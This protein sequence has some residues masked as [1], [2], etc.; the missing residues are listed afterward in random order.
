MGYKENDR[1]LLEMIAWIENDSGLGKG[2]KRTV[3]YT[4]D[5]EALDTWTEHS[6]LTCFSVYLSPS[7]HH[8]PPSPVYFLFS[9]A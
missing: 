6:W 4:F 8:G 5:V 9:G 1:W 3:L 7:R 2:E